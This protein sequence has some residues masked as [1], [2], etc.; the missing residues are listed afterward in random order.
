M[1]DLTRRSFLFLLTSLF[2]SGGLLLLTFF[3]TPVVLRLLGPDAF[4]T[5]KV[6]SELYG[7]LSLLELGLYSSLLAALIPVTASGDRE[8]QRA[9]LS[10][11]LFAYAKAA[12]VT[13]GAALLLVPLLPRLTSF[14]D[15][16]ALTGTFLMLAATAVFIPLQ[17]YRIY[18]EAS[19]QGHKVNLI[20]FA[21]NLLLLILALAF[22][23]LGLGLRSQGLAVLTST[24]VGVALLVRFAD[25]RI[26]WPRRRDPAIVSELRRHQRPQVLNDAAYKIGQNCDQLLIAFFLG[27]EAVTKVFL[28][29]RIVLILQGQ[30]QAL[31]QSSFASLGNLYYSDPAVF[32]QRALEVT[33]L[34]AVGA[35][36]VLVPV[37]LFNRSFIALWVGRE[38]LLGDDTLTL[39]AAGNAYLFGLFSFWALLFTV[40][41]KPAVLTPTLWTQALV[42]V[43]ASLAGTRLLGPPGPIAGTLVSFLVVSLWSYPRLLTVHFGLPVRA[44]LARVFGPLVVA[45]LTLGLAAALPARPDPQSWAGLIAAGTT[46]SVL[47]GVLL[48]FTMFNRAER[49]QHT[50]RMAK[51]WKVFRRG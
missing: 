13:A 40:L 14:A 10:H 7:H 41:A 45:G 17:P 34:I 51:L 44:I 3:L 28:G 9:Y 1:S 19:N 32:R 18:L 26:P 22:A 35:V 42:N 5:F 27:P 49:A 30:L 29:Q 31:G 6:L 11:G 12:A 20:A 4:G 23:A 37:C 25:V 33:K 15:H 47:Y 24:V 16:A 46:V 50:Q 38:Y 39:L 8:R 2:K 36:A 48:F 43:G 21:Q